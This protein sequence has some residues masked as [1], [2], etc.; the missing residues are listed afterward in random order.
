MDLNDEML[1]MMK[2]YEFYKK[3]KAY[4]EINE[5]TEKKQEFNIKTEGANRISKKMPPQTEGA[6]LNNKKEH[7]N[8]EIIKE[9]GKKKNYKATRPLEV[10]EYEEIIKLCK[11]GFT[12]TDKNTGRQKKFRSNPSLAF[13]LALQATLGFRASDIVNLKVSDFNRSK[14]AIKEIKTGKWQNRDLND[15]MYNKLLEYVV[16]NNLD[17]DDFI[18]PNKVRN[19]QQQLKIITDHLGY[20]NIGTHSFRKLFAHTLY[21]ES[22]YDIELVRHVLNH[23]DIKTTMRYLGVSMKKLKD[24]SDRIDFSY[25]L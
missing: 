13:A 11:E 19:M 14:F 16:I 23:S 7:K 10:E 15:V 12:Y 4:E 20:K 6:I 21:E 5:F 18:Y 3:M 9:D 24:M 1:D 2:F 8:D 25:A 22:G 17:K